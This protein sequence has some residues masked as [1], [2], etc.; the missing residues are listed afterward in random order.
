MERKP[1]G[2]ERPPVTSKKG[3]ER[4]GDTGEPSCG[5]GRGAEGIQGVMPT[6][7]DAESRGG[8]RSWGSGWEGC[9]FCLVMPTNSSNTQ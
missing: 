7:R 8:S 3:Q 4:G 6:N 9:D 1:Q 5:A 2:G